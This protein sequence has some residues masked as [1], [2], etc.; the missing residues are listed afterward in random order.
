VDIRLPDSCFRVAAECN[1][2]LGHAVF[3]SWRLHKDEIGTFQLQDELRSSLPF[4]ALTPSEFAWFQPHLRA[5][6][7]QNILNG[8]VIESL[9][10]ADGDGSR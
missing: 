2:A 1:R 5:A 8:R 6:V 9:C 7:A 4:L 10:F 3:G